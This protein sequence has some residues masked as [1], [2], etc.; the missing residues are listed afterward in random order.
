[1]SH[2]GS[3][4]HFDDKKGLE[5]SQSKL[6]CV[7]CSVYITFTLLLLLI[8]PSLLSPPPH[9]IVVCAALPLSVGYIFIDLKRPF[10]A[11]FTRP[12]IIA[13]LLPRRLTHEKRDSDL[14]RDKK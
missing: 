9:H 3:L 2:C 13:P 5:V 14:N 11:Q 6:C 4:F 7:Q 1:M 12:I 8:P 10:C